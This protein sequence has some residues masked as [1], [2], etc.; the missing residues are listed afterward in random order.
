MALLTASSVG[1]LRALVPDFERS[2]RAANK[3][4]K[5][6]EV[7]GDAARGLIRFLFERGM[8]IE[9]TKG[10]STSRPTSKTRSP[11]GNQPR[12]TSDT[13]A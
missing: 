9:A 2:L 3:S 12:P 11:D 1:D 13:G 8:P 4:A 5:T 10:G 7:Y 6:V